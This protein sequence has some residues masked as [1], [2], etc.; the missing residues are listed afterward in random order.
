KD[1]LSDRI[2]LCWRALSRRQTQHVRSSQL[3]R[4]SVDD[5]GVDSLLG[6]RGQYLDGARREERRICAFKVGKEEQFLFHGTEGDQRPPEVTSV[7][8]SPI[9]HAREPLGISG[10]GVGVK[11]LAL[12]LI[13]EAA[14]VLIAAAA[15]GEFYIGA[16]LG[17]RVRA[18]TSGLDRQ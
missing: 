12:R 17:A 8:L 14:M 10:P 7:V 13:E 16:A 5:V 18:Q 6:K 15:R 11:S 9:K 2:Q 3:V 1:C 4:S